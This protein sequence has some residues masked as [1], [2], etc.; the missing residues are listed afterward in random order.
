MAVLVEI[1]VPMT[2]DTEWID[3]IGDYLIDL[4]DELGLEEY[5]D[6]E[7]YG[8]DYIFFIAGASERTLLAAASKVA[9]RKGVPAGAFAMVTDTNAPQFGMGRRVNLPVG[10]SNGS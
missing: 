10:R 5:D 4:E 7:Q 2:D 9:T 1:H 8:D 6:G 3:D